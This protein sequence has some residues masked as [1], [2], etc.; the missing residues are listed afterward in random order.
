ME[1]FEGRGAVI[2]GG[3]NGIGLATAKE[4]ARRGARV[5]LADIDQSALDDAVAQLRSDGVDAYGVVCD[6]RKLDHVSALAD[7]A[8]R[9]LD[10][11]HV[12]FNNAGIAYA[13]P[14]TETT[15]DDW[16]FVIDVDLWGPIH[17]VEAFL[18]RLIAQGDGGHMVFTSS[19]AGLIPNVGLGPYCVAKYGVVA[20][21]E[22][23]AREVRPDGIGVTVLCPMIVETNLLANTERVRSADY[24]PAH[25]E[26]ETVQQLASAPDDDSV[27][28]VED[29][30]R[31][32]TEAILANRLYVLPH[33]ASRDSIRRRFERIDRTFDDQAAEGWTH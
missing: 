22:T 10:A 8:F 3:A 27:L 19:F 18:P 12:V 30:A 4:F 33:R 17:G 20:L 14:I 32:T 9:L 24:G 23:L 26:A 31:L 29:V 25:S 2:T 21:A 13:G 28:R 15:H 11:V 16:R 1:S 6:V 5:V 7:E